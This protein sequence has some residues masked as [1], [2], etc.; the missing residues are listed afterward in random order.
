MPG[1]TCKQGMAETT[2]GPCPPITLT[3]PGM[4]C[5]PR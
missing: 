4:P 5:L 2:Q 3:T 1:M